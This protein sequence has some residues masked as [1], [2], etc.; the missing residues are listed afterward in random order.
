ME[1]GLQNLGVLL[2]LAP[3]SW[4]SFPQTQERASSSVMAAAVVVGAWKEEFGLQTYAPTPHSVGVSGRNG[5]YEEKDEKEE[6]EKEEEQKN[7]VGIGAGVATY[8]L[9]CFYI[10]SSCSSLGS[11]T[12]VRS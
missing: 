11:C 7:Q 8:K 1:T 3:A 9:R 10:Q 6:K 12:S 4:E 5:Y 2:H